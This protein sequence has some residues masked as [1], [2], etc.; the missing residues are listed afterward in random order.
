ML[1]G[2]DIRE[3]QIYIKTYFKKQKQMEGGC[4]L[5]IGGGG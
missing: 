1:V 2:V 3:A 5:S 4:R